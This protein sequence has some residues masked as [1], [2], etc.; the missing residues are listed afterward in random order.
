MKARNTIE[1]IVIRYLK[2]KGYDGLV[3]TDVECGCELSDLFC[4]GDG[5]NQGCVP[6]YKVKPT[7]EF[8][9]AYGEAEW[10]M[11]KSKRGR[12]KS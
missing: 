2:Q 8:I 12:L 1:A 5:D 7:K 11:S 4:C 10:I 6:A 3:N 9:E